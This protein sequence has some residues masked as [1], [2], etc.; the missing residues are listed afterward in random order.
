MRWNVKPVVLREESEQ[1]IPVRPGTV[2]R[3]LVHFLEGVL[4]NTQILFG[5][6]KT[7]K[8]S[9]TVNW[10]NLIL[11]Y[12][13]HSCKCNNRLLSFAAFIEYLKYQILI[14]MESKNLFKSFVIR[15]EMANNR[16]LS[17]PTLTT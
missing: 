9:L 7:D 1:N 8:M 11:K 15:M 4:S 17:K 14:E 2:L 12:Y 5:V 13:I 3:K 10:A 16:S 6:L